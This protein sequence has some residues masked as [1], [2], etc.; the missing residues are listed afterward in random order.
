MKLRFSGF[1]WD[2]GN[3]LK[4]EKHGVSRKE[5][6]GLFLAGRFLVGSDS[7]HSHRES[8]MFAIG[9]P[10][11]TKRYIFVIFTLREIDQETLVRP[12][13]ARFMHKQEIEL[14][15]KTLTKAEE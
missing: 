3:S 13:S 6:E 1:D 9:K 2:R 7:K 8:R 15:E 4:C 14:Y 11:K 12:I 5:I 10:V